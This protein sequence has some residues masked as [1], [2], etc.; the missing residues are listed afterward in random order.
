VKKFSVSPG[1]LID[2]GGVLFEMRRS[3]NG[4]KL[5]FESQIDGDVWSINRTDFL[6]IWR[7]GNIKIISSKSSNEEITTNELNE[8]FVQDIDCFS[9]KQQ[10]DIQKRYAYIAAISEKKIKRGQ[11]LLVIEVAKAVAK[12]RKEKCPGYSSIHRWLKEYQESNDDILALARRN[13]NKGRPLISGKLREILEAAIN[14]QFLTLE[15]LPASVVWEKVDADV[16]L[17]NQ[18]AQ[19]HERLICPTQGTVRNYISKRNA[20]DVTLA[21]YG[22]REAIRRFRSVRNVNYATRILERSEMDHGLANFF[23]VD[24]ELL[25]PLG[26]PQM[27]AIRDQYSGMPQGVHFSFVPGSLYSVFACLKQAILPKDEL[28]KRFPSI[29]GDWPVWGIPE[30]L[31]MDNAP[32]FHSAELKRVAFEIQMNLQYNKAYQPWLKGGIERYIKEQNHGLL[33]R[34]PGTTFSGLMHRHDYDPEKH[35]VIRYSAFME[36][37]YKWLVDLYIR[38]PNRGKGARPIDL[39]NEGTKSTPLFLPNSTEN[40]SVAIGRSDEGTLRH[41]NIRLFN[42]I[43]ASDDLDELKKKFGNILKVAFKYDPSD[44]EKIFVK[45]PV[46]PRYIPAY[47][48]DREY[49]KNLTLWQ[50]QLIQKIARE[51]LKSKIDV[52]SLRR[53]KTLLRD[54]VANELVRRPVIVKKAAAKMAEFNS[55]SIVNG[56]SGTVKNWLTPDRTLKKEVEKVISKA[57]ASGISAEIPVFDVQIIG[58]NSGL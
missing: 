48:V 34:L 56:S 20:F 22:R 45:H 2:K 50:H 54:I 30:T 58:K 33:E 47:C 10:E 36:I 53:A 12:K 13:E 41:D 38:M 1:L 3:I 14:S 6:E 44:I 40:L 51:T 15:H 31:V 28:I 39:W 46:E 16:A 21:R 23:V 26:R 4:Q 35:A 49:A 18:V 17:Y 5:L 25:M 7:S 43:Y 37:A 27:T 42:L 9:K 52:D 55:E 57:K 19:P 32:Q 24:D 8:N 29:V 11:K